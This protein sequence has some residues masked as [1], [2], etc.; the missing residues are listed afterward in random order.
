MPV[1]TTHKAVLGYGCSHKDQSRCGN[2]SIKWIL[3]L[4]VTVKITV[5]KLVLENGPDEGAIHPKL[6]LKHS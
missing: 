2:I 5:R 3:N 4:L 6:P 1:V